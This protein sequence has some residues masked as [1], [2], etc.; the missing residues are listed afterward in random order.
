MDIRIAGSDRIVPRD[1]GANPNAGDGGFCSD[2]DAAAIPIFRVALPEDTLERFELGVGLGLNLWAQY[3][4][5]DPDRTL[6]VSTSG[7]V[8][9]PLYSQTVHCDAGRLVRGKLAGDA[10][11]NGV[12]L[13]DGEE[14][15]FSENYGLLAGV[16]RDD[17]ATDSEVLLSG[18]HRIE[19]SGDET[20]TQESRVVGGVLREREFFYG[21]E[22]SVG[23]AVSFYPDGAFKSA[24]LPRDE[25]VS[26]IFFAAGTMIEFTQDGHLASGTMRDPLRI[27]DIDF[28]ERSEVSFHDSGA[29]RSTLLPHEKYFKTRDCGIVALAAGREIEFDEDGNLIRGTLRDPKTVRS[30]DQE[31]VFAAGGEIEF[32]ADG[33][34][35]SGI[36]AEEILFNGIPLASGHRIS[37]HENG[38][39][40]EGWLAR[41][42]RIPGLEIDAVFSSDDVFFDMDG[43]FGGGDLAAE[44]VLPHHFDDE[45][46][47]IVLAGRWCS[48]FPDGSVEGGRLAHEIVMAGLP[49]TK[50]SKIKF[51]DDK[52]LRKGVLSQDASVF[53]DR[54]DDAVVFASGTDAGYDGDNFYGHLAKGVS[55]DV[56]LGERSVTLPMSQ[57]ARIQFAK[58]SERIEGGVLSDDVTVWPGITFA[59]GEWFEIDLRGS[60]YFSEP[61]DDDDPPAI[62]GTLKKS[63]KI[64]GHELPDGQF[65]KFYPSGKVLGYKPRDA[66]IPDPE[67]YPEVVLGDNRWVEFYEG[68]DWPRGGKLVRDARI[69]PDL[70]PD[71]DNPL[72]LAQDKWVEFDADG[73]L[74]GGKLAQNF[75]ATTRYGPITLCEGEWV[76]LNE[77]G[78]V[79]GGRLQ[80]DVSL[81]LPDFDNVVFAAGEWVDFDEEGALTGGVL[82]QDATYFHPLYGEVVFSAGARV[83]FYSDGTFKG[84]VLGES[85]AIYNSRYGEFTLQPDAWCEFYEDGAFKSG[86]LEGELFVI[87]DVAGDFYVMGGEEAHFYPAE[88][89]ARGVLSETMALNTDVGMIEFL[90]GREIELADD[91]AVSAGY[92]A[93]R[94]VIDGVSYRFGQWVAIEPGR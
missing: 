57:G 76:D 68:T 87:N 75:V 3:E 7:G 15:A 41:E 51:N 19:F 84:G 55:F 5:P 81:I 36:L 90:K 29:L 80:D 70:Y 66:W 71:S 86:T 53:P 32:Y 67:F 2:E 83:E 16:P 1:E 23:S 93:R 13:V 28:P 8:S 40:F 20:L 65:V 26:G 9:I 27:N 33:A 59:E 44:A 72:V 18:G 63:F 14:V 64:D 21:I 35:K 60:E 17:V 52:T 49:L 34:I 4:Y 85:L 92:L 42:F 50:G 24:M 94:Y 56:V 46:D 31:F 12:W 69:F 6:V 38:A 37:F 58:D 54:Y 30:G 78:G 22:F 48:F 62:G 79:L 89:L 11:V 82:A 77:V 73:I 45:G 91:E 47:P 74:T 43:H 10:L 88:S 39:V 25:K 61:S